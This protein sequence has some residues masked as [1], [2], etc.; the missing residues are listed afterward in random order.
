M[1]RHL[2]I[3]AL[4]AAAAAIISCEENNAYELNVTPSID[5]TS[6]ANIAFKAIGGTGAIEVAPVEGQLQVTTAQSDWC[7]LTV[8]GNRIEVSVDNYG[9]LES[10]YAVLD[11]KAGNAVGQTIVH[12]F[13]VIVKAFDWKDF[14][15]KNEAQNV[16][17]TYDANGSTVQATSAADWLSFEATPEK[18]TVHVDANPTTDYREALVH[19]TIGEVQGDITV[20][21]FDLAAAGLLG[22]WDWHGKQ[23]PNNRDFPMQATLSEQSDGA[24]ALS[25]H[26]ATTTVEIDM[27]VGDIVLEANKLMLPLGGK[28]GTYTMKRT[29]TVYYAYPVVASGTGRIFYNDAVTTGA[30]PFVLSKNDAGVWQAVSNLS[31]WPDMLFRFEMW[32]PPTDAYEEEHENISSSGLILAESYME[33]L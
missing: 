10:R 30:V 12:Q 29:G 21:Q 24:Y 32:T 20:G 1:R 31:A 13:G 2:A 6:G 18:F 19:W 33:K 11:M 5:V 15:V 22:D 7:H 4:V 9:G 3:L 17:F 16:E 27:T 28:V 8:S 23:Q 26:Y 25:L 14:T